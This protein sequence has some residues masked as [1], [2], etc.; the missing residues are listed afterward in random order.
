VARRRLGAALRELRTAAGLR[1]EDAARELDCSNAKVSRLETGKGVPRQR[2]VRDLVA[3]YGPS[4]EVRRDELLAL[5]VESLSESGGLATDFRDVFDT[6]MVSDDQARLIA[7]EQDAKVKKS[8]EAGLF[9]GLLQAES[10]A[11]AVAEI[12]FSD[13]DE[14]QRKRFVELRLGRQERLL[15]AEDDRLE[16]LVIQSEQVLRRPVGG[17]A[18]LREQLDHLV[19]G[20]RDG[21]AHVEF[22]IAPFSLLTPV[23]LGSSFSIL[24]F[25]DGSDQD[26]VYLEGATG[27]VYYETDEQVQRYRRHYRSLLDACPSRDESIKILEDAAQNLT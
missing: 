11:R 14:A 13:R 18:V 8:F 9:G 26:V 7:L 23:A 3:L 4:A 27:A 20:L 22:R 15:A 5:V 21:L 16:L 24:E 17:V 12:Y 25:A 1:I 6:G 10:Y 19:H 2:D